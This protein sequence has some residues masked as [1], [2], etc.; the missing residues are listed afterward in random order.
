MKYT[1]ACVLALALLGLGQW[2][3]AEP[4]RAEHETP[5]DIGL[6]EIRVDVVDLAMA[7]YDEHLDRRVTVH[8]GPFFGTAFGPEVTF[9]LP[10]GESLRAAV[11]VLENERTLV[12]YPPPGV[13]G[14]VEVRV[15]N[16]DRALIQ[17]VTQL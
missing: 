8:G 11:V 13:R 10:D 17:G 9:V 1:L 12:A 2:L 7:G 14:S 6:S 15:E 4:V 3:L 16:P 5:A